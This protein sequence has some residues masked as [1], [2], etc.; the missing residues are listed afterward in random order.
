[1]EFIKAFL[2]FLLFVILMTAVFLIL[3]YIIYL[4]LISYQALLRKLK[5]TKPNYKH[6]IKPTK[7]MLKYAIAIYLGACA[8]FYAYKTNEYLLSDRPHKEAKAYA[9]AGEY[10]FIWQSIFGN[11][12]T[13]GTFLFQPLEKLQKVFVLDPIYRL[14]PE[15]DAERDI[16]RYRLVLN[17]YARS[18]WAPVTDEDKKAGRTFIYVNASYKPELISLLLDIYDA[19]IRL[20]EVHIQDKEFSDTDRYLY[21]A[22]ML[23]YYM[24]YYEKQIDLAYKKGSNKRKVFYETTAYREQYK[25][26][27]NVIDITKEAI[28]KDE[29]LAKSFEAMPNTKAFFYWGAIGA[30]SIFMSDEI[31]YDDSHPCG[32]KTVKQ[33]TKYQNEFLAWMNDPRSSFARL[34]RKRRNQYRFRISDPSEDLHYVAKYI[35]GERFDTLN[36]YEQVAIDWGQATEENL[37]ATLRFFKEKRGLEATQEFF[38][39]VRD[40]EKNHKEQQGDD[41]GR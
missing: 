31:Y 27:L 40:N 24:M 4:I 29:K 15:S 2:V 20:S 17:F 6:P 41:N 13:I 7:K 8:F 19:T 33:Y 11:Y 38:K 14:I 32:T 37:T 16:W 5:K 9:I 3:L 12:R 28:E 34:D 39:M 1:L 18:Y 35:C 23:P 26:F 25:N 30:Y 36:R 10:M 21:I 22:M